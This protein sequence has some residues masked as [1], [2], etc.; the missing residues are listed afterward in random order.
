MLRCITCDSSRAALLPRPARAGY[1]WSFLDG[2]AGFVDHGLPGLR[3]RAALVGGKLAVRSQLG[4][5]TEIEFTIPA[6]LA[7]GT[8]TRGL[9][10]RIAGTSFKAANR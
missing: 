7:Y 5:G 9:L 10:R 3:E 1:D 8:S 6:P 2:L 4:S